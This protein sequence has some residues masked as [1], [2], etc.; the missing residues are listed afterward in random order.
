MLRQATYRPAIS[1]DRQVSGLRVSRQGYLATMA[2]GTVVY[3]L[4]PSGIMGHSHNHT[5]ATGLCGRL[6]LQ[7]W[8]LVDHPQG[9]VCRHGAPCKTIQLLCMYS[10]SKRTCMAQH[11]GSIR[12]IQVLVRT[13]PHHP[14]SAM[15]QLPNTQGQSR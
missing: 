4:R 7:T 8:R 9:E 2:G 13:C 10:N 15:L 6:A 14:V 11:N 5:Q 3:I 1:I 12:A